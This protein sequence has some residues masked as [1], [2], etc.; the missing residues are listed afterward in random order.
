M[1]DQAPSNTS[2][3]QLPYLDEY[4]HAILRPRAE[5]TL[6]VVSK[7]LNESVWQHLVRLLTAEQ[8][9]ATDGTP[10]MIRSLLEDR[11]G[12][13]IEVS[14]A[15]SFAEGTAAPKGEPPA[16]QVVVPGKP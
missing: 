11:L 10:A 15:S 9:A 8:P 12:L 3:S 4:L 16:P 2:F 6:Q 13:R 7:A 1:P 14:L 5:R